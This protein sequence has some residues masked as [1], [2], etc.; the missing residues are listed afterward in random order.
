MH[1]SN[2]RDIARWAYLTKGLG[3][4]PNEQDRWNCMI[5][6]FTAA[7]LVAGIMGLILGQTS[8]PIWLRAVF[9]IGGFVGTILVAN[10]V[11][12]QRAYSARQEKQAAPKT[13]PKPAPTSAPKAVSPAAKPTPAPAPVVAAAPEAATGAGTKPAILGAPRD[14]NADDLKLIKGVG[15][16]LEAVCN[17]LG[18]WHFDQIS[19]WT[20]DEIAWVDQNLEGFKGR[21]T[22]DDWVTQAKILAGGGETEFSKRQ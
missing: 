12:T 5:L 2:E 11:C 18:F 3:A 20:A 22:R 14:G 19:N 4:D 1:Q 10:K 16:K 9:F 13:A 7:M 21:V 8:I 6:S 15:P 17:K